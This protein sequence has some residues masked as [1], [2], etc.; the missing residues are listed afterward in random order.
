MAAHDW[1]RV[2]AG[3]FHSF[4]LGWIAELTRTLNGGLL[5]ADYY[6]LSEQRAAE[7]EPDLLALERREDGANESHDPGPDEPHG[8]G[9][10]IA[11]AR[12]KAHIVGE[13]DEASLYALKR[14]TVTIRHATNDRIVA[15]LEVVS[16]GNKDRPLSVQRFVDKSVAALQSGY[17][18]VVV[19]LFPPRPS[20]PAGLTSAV[21]EEV[22]GKRIDWPAGR[23]LSA[24]SFRVAD[25]IQ[26]YAEAFAPGEPVPE[27]P[28]FYDPDWYVNLPLEATYMAAYEG[29]PR[30]WKRVIEGRGPQGT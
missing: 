2:N 23:P 29:V 30:R 14:R 7:F 20:D 16:P 22:G 1:T 27:L 24:A 5:P 10:A 4:H 13:V 17:H 15:L 26:C 9:T 6:A 19:D 18:L 8:G 3:T 11:V 28:L 21:W 25:R 12:P